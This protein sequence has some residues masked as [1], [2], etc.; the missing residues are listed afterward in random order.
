G[1][2][3]ELHVAPNLSFFQNLV[4][5]G[6]AILDP[7]TKE[8]WDQIQ[9]SD[10]GTARLLRS[11]EEYANTLAQN[12]RKTYLKP[13]TIVTD[14]MSKCFKAPVCRYVWGLTFLCPSSLVCFSSNCGL[15]GCVR[16]TE[17]HLTALPGHPGVLP[18]GAR[19]LRSIPQV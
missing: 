9:R 6:S 5:A 18:Q 19:L 8:H 4:R 11:F 12:V 3:K 7:N 14:N 16:P 13:F 10:G 15:P 1:G 2:V 17:G